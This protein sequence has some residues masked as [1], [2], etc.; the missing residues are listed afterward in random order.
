MASYQV[1]PTRDPETSF[2]DRIALCRRIL[3]LFAIHG[4]Q[5]ST[6]SRAT[7]NLLV[8]HHLKP[9]TLAI[10]LV[11]GEFLGCNLVNT[12]SHYLCLLMPLL[13][14]QCRAAWRRT[15]TDGKRL[16]Y[17]ILILFRIRLC[18]TCYMNLAKLR[19]L[20]LCMLSIQIMACLK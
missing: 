18:W 8:F 16:R 12:P 5:M 11:C 15:V 2:W 3:P 14:C 4:Q 17:L 13:A 10:H 20:M 7:S 19:S 9:Q 1:I 6:H